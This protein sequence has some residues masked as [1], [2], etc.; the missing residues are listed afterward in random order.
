M[1]AARSAP[2]AVALQRA[3]YVRDVVD[4]CRGKRG[5][6]ALKVHSD[7]VWDE[8]LEKTW[9]YFIMGVSAHWLALIDEVSREQGEVPAAL[10]PMLDHYRAVQ[11]EVNEIWRFQGRHA[12]LHHLNAIFGYEP[13]LIQRF[14]GF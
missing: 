7:P 6:A 8:R 9:P 3:G 12:Y 14:M 5:Q 4:T 2:V 10:E 1:V 13:L 11:E